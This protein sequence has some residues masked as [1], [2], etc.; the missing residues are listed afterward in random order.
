MVARSADSLSM[1]FFSLYKFLAA[2][3][4]VRGIILL[5]E[6]YTFLN[7]IRDLQSDPHLTIPAHATQEEQRLEAI[8]GFTAEKHKT[9]LDSFSRK[10]DTFSV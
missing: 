1:G 3:L 8:T 10:E 6:S 2:L 4:L 9:I 5:L 7:V